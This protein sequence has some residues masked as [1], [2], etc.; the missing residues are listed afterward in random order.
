MRLGSRCRSQARRSGSKGTAATDEN[1]D[2][3][4]DDEDFDDEDILQVFMAAA[5]GAAVMKF[6]R[7]LTQFECDSVCILNICLRD[8]CHKSNVCSDNRP[9]CLE[10]G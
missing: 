1:E 2:G 8:L 6:I 9:Y 3:G 5:T 7:G 10:H 4:E